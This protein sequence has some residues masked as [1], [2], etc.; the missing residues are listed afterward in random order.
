MLL[1][2]TFHIGFALSLY[3]SKS[4]ILFVWFFQAPKRDSRAVKQ[5]GLAAKLPWFNWNGYEIPINIE[6]TMKFPVVMLTYGRY[7]WHKHH[8]AFI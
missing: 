8:W 1:N 4:Q 2:Q 3:L 5:N 6:I 7:K